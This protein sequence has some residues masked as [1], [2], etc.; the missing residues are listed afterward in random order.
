MKS[1][2]ISI[3]ILLISVC[4]NIILTVIISSGTTN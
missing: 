1:I 4:N 2:I 3:L